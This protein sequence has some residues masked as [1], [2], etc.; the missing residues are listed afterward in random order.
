[1]LSE[2]FINRPRFAMVISIVITI[3]GLISIFSLPVAQYPDITPPQV[4][5][6]TSYPG[7]SAD[8]VLKSVVQPLESEVNGVKDMIYMESK[9]DNTGA[10]NTTVTFDLGTNSDMD[11]VNTNNRVS[12]ATPQLPEE[13]KRQGVSVKEKSSNMLLIINLYSP[14]GTYD[15]IYLSNYASIYIQDA[16]SRIRGIGDATILGQ[17]D[18]SMRIW[19]DPDR[20]TNHDLTADDVAQAIEEQNVQVAAGQIGAPPAP[21]NQQIELTVQTLGR[22]E[23]VEQFKEII[24]RA[25]PDGST[26]KIKDVAEVEL[27]AKTYSAY[28][29]LNGKPSVLLAIY[30]LSD[31]NGLQI[32]GQVKAELAKIA[33]DFPEDLEYAVLYDTTK[34]IENSIDEVVRTLFEAVFLVILVVFIFLQDWRSTLVPTLAIPVSLVGTFAA[35]L[36]LGFSINL[37]TLFGLILAI[38]IVVDDAIVVIE[39]INHLMDTENLSPKEAAIKSMRQV[40]G[41]V[42]ATTLVLLA[43]FVPVCFM[44][45]ITGQLYRQF[46]VT[47]SISVVISS[48]NALTLSPALSACLLKPGKREPFILFRWFNSFLDSFTAGYMA[49]VGRLIKKSLF[50]II[51][52]AILL[53]TTYRLYSSLPTGF[54]PTEDQGA[55]MVD[56]QLPDGAS[57]ERTAK[58]V[59]QARE[60]LATIPGVIDVMNTNGFSIL[61]SMN[62]SNSA[63]MVVVLEDWARRETPELSLWSILGEAQRRLNDIPG[64]NIIAFEMSPIPGLG[65]TGGFEFVLQS[66]GNGDFRDL[67]ATANEV[68]RAANERPEIAR[69]YTTFRS[70]VP[71]LFVNIDRAKAKK[72]GV[73]LKAVFSTLQAQL[74]SYYIN[75]FNRFGKVYQVNMQ[76]SKK[77]RDRPRDIGKLYVRNDKGEMVPLNTLVTVTEIFGPQY[78]QRY[79]MF[80]ALTINGA[81]APGYSSGQAMKTMEEVADQIMPSGYQYSWT[82]MS[83]QEKLA[84]NLVVIIF[85]LA[86]TFMYLFLVAQYESWMLPWAIMLSVPI[87]FFGAILALC[88]RGMINNIYTQVGF[89]L[90]FGLAAKTAILIVE[91]AKEERQGGKS[92]ID[93]AASAAKLRFR[94]VLMTAIS[95]VLGVMPL[96]IA[97]GAGAVSRQS[98][99]T[100]VCGGM[101]ISMIFGTI[102]TPSFFVIIQTT[103][104]K[105]KKNPAGTDEQKT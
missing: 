21:A 61:T 85:A 53:F 100:A 103:V 7:A 78:L 50:V 47:I 68:I 31:A 43:V 98:L 54:V 45:G 33:K 20:L 75:E 17:Q 99:G 63:F 59:D 84:G 8:T 81:A 56:V 32:A 49:I 97:T 96:V 60:K 46:A 52:F 69:A 72:L 105:F 4:A 94:A 101:I 65:T 71:Q 5:V 40:T 26:V 1:M 35:L 91:F 2:F 13:V 67:M 30:Q 83:Y 87:A 11:V 12:T 104:E 22:L 18:Y 57:L 34:F 25:E 24:I 90:L 42:I 80:L 89:V 95:F 66:T 37:T 48:I 58:I 70:A 3:A 23:D 39:N 16:I 51:A 27:G 41:P 92:I 9:C 28:G 29:N 76:A 86:L 44:P 73:P 82:G 10:L 74:G 14:N 77:Y 36:V 64:A 88:L 79:N 93:A 19:L 6:S 102:L 55:F 38:G 15:G 62:S